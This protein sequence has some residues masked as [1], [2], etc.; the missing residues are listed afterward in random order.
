[1]RMLA[2]V[3]LKRGGFKVVEEAEDGPQGLARFLDLNSPARPLGRPPRQPHARSH[4]AG[5][6]RT[7]AVPAPHP[8]DRPLLGTSSTTRSKGGGTQAS[9]S[10]RASRRWRCRDFRK[11]SGRC[12][13]RRNETTGSRSRRSG[14]PPPRTPRARG[15]VPSPRR[16]SPSPDGVSST[17][18]PQ[19][20]C[21]PGGAG[22]RGERRCHTGTD[23]KARLVISPLTGHVLPHGHARATSSYAMSGRSSQ[24]HRFDQCHASSWLLAYA[25]WR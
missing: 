25:R 15:V 10:L 6:R 9:A 12:C 7:N 23:L 18:V 11:S 19:G 8:D 2:G 17:A 21:K 24:E 4:R 13:G 5:G 20:P 16:G 14:P 3:F 22:P 1:M